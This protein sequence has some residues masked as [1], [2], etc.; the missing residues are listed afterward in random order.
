MRRCVVFGSLIA[1]LAVAVVAQDAPTS[2]PPEKEHEWLKQLV[3]EWESEMETA[4]V[5]GMP[6]MKCTG[7]MKTRTLGGYWIVSDV[8]NDMMG[9]K[10]DAVQ[11]VGYDP[12]A[13]KYVGTWVDSM[14]NHLWKYEG[15]VDDTGKILTLEADGPNFLGGEGTAKYRDVYEITGKD[16]FETKSQMQTP[17][18]KWM[19]FMTGKAKRKAAK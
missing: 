4:S 5:P 2:P 16:T 7:T 1:L 17:D 6:A 11:T 14:F 15:T 13:K 3:G 12:K 8:H 19:T 9:Q 18:G 10:V